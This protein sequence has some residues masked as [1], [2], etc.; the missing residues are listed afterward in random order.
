MQKT[1]TIHAP[2]HTTA[3]HAPQHKPA[4]ELV[5]VHAPQHRRAVA[6]AALGRGGAGVRRRRVA[7][8]RRR[9]AALLAPA[10]LGGLCDVGGAGGDVVWS[11]LWNPAAAL[12]RPKPG[13][14][15][16]QGYNPKRPPSAAAAAPP[17]LRLPGLP[18][19]PLLPGASASPASS[20]GSVKRT[21]AAAES[22]R[23]GHSK[24]RPAVRCVARRRRRLPQR[25]SAAQRGAAQRSTAQHSTRAHPA[26]TP[27][28][29]PPPAAAGAG[30]LP[31]RCP[32]WAPPRACA[33]WGA[34][35]GAQGQVGAGQG[36]ARVWVKQAVGRGRA[37]AAAV[38]HGVE[39]EEKASTTSAIQRG[40]Q[41]RQPAAGGRLG[42]GAPHVG[43][44]RRQRAG[45]HALH[46]ALNHQRPE[47]VAQHLRKATGVGCRV[48]TERAGHAPAAGASPAAL[49][50][51]TP[52]SSSQHSSQAQHSK[53][54][55]S[56]HSSQ[57]QHSTAQHSAAQP[58]QPA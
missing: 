3:I 35:A 12:V 47:L 1:A 51:G 15:A 40:Q 38:V 41:R 2:Q 11:V 17:R 32:A 23:G 43:G 36:R 54:Q 37:L 55:H 58:A 56:Q 42:G 14:P 26:G 49:R 24:V 27:A 7:A 20:S 34:P 50:P 21:A 46:V 6:V 18:P 19:A 4:V 48:V 5:V 16:P 33:R 25:G 30:P 13:F 44:R 8:R 52:P 39:D 31:P 45:R 29:W 57:A 28:A 22:G 9:V 10:L 53:A